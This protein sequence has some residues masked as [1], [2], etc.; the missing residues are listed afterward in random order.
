MN[1]SD[2]LSAVKTLYSI[3]CKVKENKT[4][5]LRLSN[6]I[7]HIVLSLEDFRRRDVIREMD[8]ND[9]MTVISDIILRTERLTQR[10]LKR[11][12]GDRTWNAL[13]ISLEISRLN[14]DLK[15]YLSVHTI[16]ALNIMQSSQSEQYGMLSAS[17]EEI[18]VKLAELDLRLRPR[19]GDSWAPNI[20]AQAQTNQAEARE[21][22]MDIPISST[23]W[24]PYEGID[25]QA[26]TESARTTLTIR[27]L[28]RHESSQF[29]TL[30]R[31]VKIKTSYDEIIQLIVA[32]GYLRPRSLIEDRREL[33]ITVVDGASSY[34]GTLP[35]G[36]QISRTEPLRWWYNK[37]AEYHGIAQSSTPGQTVA[38]LDLRLGGI[39]VGGTRIRFHRTLRVPEGPNGTTSRLPPNLGQYPLLPLSKL[40]EARLP[41]SIRGKGGFIMPMFKK[42]ALCIFFVDLYDNFRSHNAIK[43]SVGGVNVISGT[44]NKTITPPSVEQDYIVTNQQPRLDGIVTGPG[45]VRQA[46]I[47]PTNL[48][49]IVRLILIRSRSSSLWLP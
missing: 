18:T 37:Y 24:I 25:F 39:K 31:D 46:S 32:A 40:D 41:M 33:S 35:G 13:E 10:L 45:V 6:R 49:A 8:Y 38:E 28:L 2:A 16:S 36:L 1:A 34:D 3:V 9:A 17:I 11:S 44:V 30:V 26:M 48:G 12:L 23:K 43:V 42:E 7:Q 5:L 29:E 15:N 14:E 20:V 21:Q 47:D 4:E 19:D 22:P 27:G